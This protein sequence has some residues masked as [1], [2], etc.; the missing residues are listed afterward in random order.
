MIRRYAVTFS[1]GSAVLSWMTV[2]SRSK[3]RPIKSGAFTFS[4]EIAQEKLIIMAKNTLLL[5]SAPLETG[6]ILPLKTIPR[7]SRLMNT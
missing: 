2:P 6:P 7:Q 3:K 5:M 4:A 1:N